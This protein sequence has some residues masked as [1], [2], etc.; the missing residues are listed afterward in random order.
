MPT[1]A[2]AIVTDGHG[3]FAIEAVTLGDP[4][5]NEVLV[6]IH[7]SGV[8]HTDF[9][10]M[11]WGRRIIMGHEGAGIVMATGHG[12]T[13]VKP[14]D[15]VLLNWAIP[16]GRCF[17]CRRGAENI[18]ENQPVV[19]DARFGGDLNASFHLGT[20]STHTL[21]PAQAVVPIQVEIP[22]PQAAILGCCV[23]TG[24]GSV[25]NVARVH[26]GASVVV[27]G[28]GGVGLSVIMGAVHANAA[29]I[30]AVDLNQHRLELARRMGATDT[31][32][33]NSADTGLLKVA[34]NIHTLLGRGADYAFECTAVPELGAAPLAMVRNGGTA[35]AVSGIE[36][37]VSMDMQLFEWDK[38]Y[39]NPLYGQCRPF[40]DFPKLLALYAAGSLNLDEMI[41]RTYPL[42]GLAEAF[43]HM[44]LGLNAKGVLLPHG[45]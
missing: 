11:H 20:M 25:S 34:A 45:A 36:Q 41:T 22:F 42:T 14:G 9:D 15:R 28:C 4:E 13:H 24:F 18:C 31:V 3:Q 21:V 35:V 32:Q 26:E 16:C 1:H 40:I 6:K 10:S 29:K 5:H 38:T 33:A 8:C 17:Q 7:A 43:E 12:V 30:I 37:F 39:I 19:P 2:Q 27:L 44:R 23:M